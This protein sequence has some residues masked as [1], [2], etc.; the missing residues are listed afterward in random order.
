MS[1]PVLTPIRDSFPPWPLSQVWFPPC[2]PHDTI[3]PRCGSILQNQA[4]EATAPPGPQ[5]QSNL[6]RGW[7]VGNQEREE[8]G[9][10]LRERG[11]RKAALGWHL[12]PETQPALKGVLPNTHHFLG[13][14]LIFVSTKIPKSSSHIYPQW[15]GQEY[16]LV[17]LPSVRTQSVPG[18][19]T[20][21]AWAPQI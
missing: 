18:P 14:L 15:R 3:S 1:K 12:R 16:L 19:S 17:S 20:L 4:G 2:R 21:E 13:A 6:S 11:W 9:K 5:L 8:R 7:G 10:E